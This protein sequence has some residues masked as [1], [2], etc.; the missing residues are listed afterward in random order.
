MTT[1]AAISRKRLCFVEIRVENKTVDINIPP[2]MRSIF[3]VRIDVHSVALWTAAARAERALQPER[4]EAL[5]S[6]HVHRWL[7]A[8]QW[9]S[10]ELKSNPVQNAIEAAE[11]LRFA[12]EKTPT[13][14]SEGVIVMVDNFSLAKCLV[15]Q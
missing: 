7:R 5:Q 1:R 11:E 14:L 12:A 8:R 3:I 9:C 13:G 6:T 15:S 2:K 4:C 10:A